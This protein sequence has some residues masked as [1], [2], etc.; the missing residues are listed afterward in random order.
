MI[1][2]EGAWGI[3]GLSGQL[4]IRPFVKVGTTI[5]F[6]M[7]NKTYI[8]ETFLTIIRNTFV[9]LSVENLYF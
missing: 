7:K 1:N 4:N 3:G 8:D 2:D 5:S 6:R 9:T